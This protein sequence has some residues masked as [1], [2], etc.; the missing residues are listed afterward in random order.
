MPAPTLLDPKLDVVFKRQFV[1]QHDLL[2]DLINAVRSEEPPV[3][4]LDILNPEIRPEELTGKYIVLD[5]LARD[6]Q[7]RQFNLEMQANVHAGWTARSVYY[8]ARILGNQLHSGGGYQHVQ[9]VIGIHLMNFELFSEP[10]QACWRFEM[11]DHLRPEVVLDRSLQ[12]HM[13]ELPKAERTQAASQIPQALADWITYFR[14]W[15]EE[16]IMRTIERPAIQKAYQH[17][18]ALSGDDLARHQAFVRERA[19]RDEITEKAFAEAKGRTEGRTE[20]QTDLLR[21]LL[22]AKFGELPPSAEQR[23]RH[24]E[25]T[26]LEHWAEQVLFAER[27]EQVFGDH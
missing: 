10:G 11:R 7:G 21:R 2:I 9:P 16:S 24:A 25:P 14:H 18:H 1:E 26:Q 6:V 17:L 4:E 8:L 27:L 3:V 5:I 13:I 19:L 15:Q 20:G 12:L 22:R 23:L